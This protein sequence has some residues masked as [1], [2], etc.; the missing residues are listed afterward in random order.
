MNQA[1]IWLVVKPTVGL[2]LFLGA[3][4]VTALLV[5][6]SLLTHTTWFSAYWNGG[7]KAAV[8][9]AAPAPAVEAAAPAAQ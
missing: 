6:Y 3:V 9:A 1:K 2:P 4:A 5:H 7:H 8:A